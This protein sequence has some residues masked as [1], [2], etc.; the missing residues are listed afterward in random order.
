MSLSP[1]TVALIVAIGGFLVP[2][3]TSVV[4]REKWSAQVKQLVAAVLSVAVA[5]TAIEITDPA[6]FGLGFAALAG[7]VY[8]GS[9]AAYALFRGS[10]VETA[11]ASIGS[12]SAKPVASSTA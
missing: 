2:P 1:Q 9:Q 5:G 4:K 12:K 3:L 11:L 7:L 8:T 10:A 6:A